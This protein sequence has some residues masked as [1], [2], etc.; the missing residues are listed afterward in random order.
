MKSN[1]HKQLKEAHAGGF[2]AADVGG[3]HAR[4]ALVGP[5][6][7]G[8]SAF[9]IE[10]YRK[11]RCAEFDGLE[12]IFETFRAEVVQGPIRS[13]ALAIAGCI[14]DDSVINV[15][16]PWSVSISALRNALGVHELA[17]TN[18]FEAVA[19]AIGYIDI[20]SATLLTG[21][22]TAPSGPMLV[23]GPGTGL[24]AAVRIPQAGGA[25]ILATEAGQ[26]NLAAA[27]DFEIDI[28][29][30]LRTQG[31]MVAIENVLSG[32]GLKNLH[33]AIRRLRGAS[34]LPLAPPQITAAA[35]DRSDPLAVET[36]EVFCAWFG[37]VLGDL[38]LLY[39]ARGGICLAGGVL[40]QMKELLVRSAFVERFLDKGAMREALARIPVR[41]VDHAQLGVI[42]AAGW[43]F[44]REQNSPQAT[45]GIATSRNGV[46]ATMDSK[47]PANDARATCP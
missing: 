42:G 15:N 25:V 26:A 19:H 12:A 47:E 38:A 36:V 27:S 33:A 16:L 28:L 35:L 7:D 29:R 30:E 41:L 11:Y 31:G 6:V 37:S 3:T 43:Y 21:P 24:G 10:H 32:T 5:G 34:P 14:V 39:G 44:D 18:D 17:I 8:Q 13:I 20:A 40:P 45:Q 23:V 46:S 22:Q 9:S 4:M 2:I 1:G